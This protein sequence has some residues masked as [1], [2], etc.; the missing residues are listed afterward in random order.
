[1]KVRHSGFRNPAAYVFIAGSWNRDNAIAAFIC[2]KYS[3][4]LKATT[5]GSI[6]GEILDSLSKIVF[7]IS[8][9]ISVN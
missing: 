6:D 4:S 8:V 5:K 3:E 9:I 2:A 1:M 7:V